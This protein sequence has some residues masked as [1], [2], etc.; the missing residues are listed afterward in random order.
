[1]EVKVDKMAEANQ[2]LL[3]ILFDHIRQGCPVCDKWRDHFN[4]DIRVFAEQVS[5]GII[6]EVENQ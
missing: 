1:M 4:E 5:L 2:Y 6:T 3:D